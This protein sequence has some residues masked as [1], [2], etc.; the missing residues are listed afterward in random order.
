MV[1]V[2]ETPVTEPDQ[3]MCP[4]GAIRPAVGPATD[5]PEVAAIRRPDT[6]GE[7]LF[8]AY[9]MVDWS[10]SSVPVQVRQFDLGRLGLVGG[11]RADRGQCEQG[12]AGRR[13]GIHP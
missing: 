4:P 7:P 9:V 8:D 3:A 10:S 12:D 1:R 6:A 13:I 5:A 11:R 2:I